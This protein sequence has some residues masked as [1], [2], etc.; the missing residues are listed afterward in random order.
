MRTRVYSCARYGTV[1][2]PYLLGYDGWY[3]NRPVPVSPV[4]D[5]CYETDKADEVSGG[6]FN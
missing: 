1:L 3:G 6:W 4:G 2:H 5:S